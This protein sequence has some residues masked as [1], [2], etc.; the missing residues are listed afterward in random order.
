MQMLCASMPFCLSHRLKQAASRT[1]RFNGAGP[2]YVNVRFSQWQDNG[3]RVIV[4]PKDMRTGKLIM[5]PWM[6]R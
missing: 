4:W 6:R 3:A 1:C 2:G 5:P